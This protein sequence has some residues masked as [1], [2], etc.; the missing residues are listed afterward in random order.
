MLL[1]PYNYLKNQLSSIAEIK[2]IDWFNDQYSG[3][4]HTA[5]AVFI[6]FPGNLRFET[7]RKNVQQAPF[8][9][10]IHT[11]SKV[12]MNADNSIDAASIQLHENI[13]DAIYA[14]LQGCRL[15]DTDRLLCNSLSRSVYEHHQYLQGWMVTTQDFES[16]IYQHE[17]PAITI[18]RPDVE[19]TQA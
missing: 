6:E 8:I 18:P 12:L 10:R 3:T 7:L 9:A 15:I 17:V 11:I 4:I 14:R 1:K 2:L 19:I 16:V 5:P 13:N